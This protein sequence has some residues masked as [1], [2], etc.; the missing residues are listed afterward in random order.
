MNNNHWSLNLVMKK[1]LL[2][3]MT[4]RWCDSQGQRH[5]IELGVIGNW[6]AACRKPKQNKRIAIKSSKEL[7]YS[8]LCYLAIRTVFCL[9]FSCLLPPLKK[10]RAS[11]V[12]QMVKNLPTIQETKVQSLG[13]EG[14]L[15]KWM[16][17]HSSI[18]AWRIPWTEELVGYNT[19][20]RKESDTTKWLSMH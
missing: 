15:E 1:S 8:L 11:L 19:W 13:Q 4:G 9:F 2:T 5:L 7:G 16:T 14:P 17:T 12:A 10:E 18:R 20:G 3:L 6:R